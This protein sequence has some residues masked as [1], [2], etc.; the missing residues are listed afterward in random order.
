MR[1]GSSRTNEVIPDDFQT[2]LASL[3]DRCGNVEAIL[4]QGRTPLC[5]AHLYGC[6]AEIRAQLNRIGIGRGDRVAAA[7]PRGP[8]TAV[9]FFGVA[10]CATY[11]PLNPDYSEDEFGRYLARLQPKAV[12]VRNGDGAAIRNA[13]TQ[14]GIRIV[15]LVAVETGPAGKFELRCDDSGT[16]AEPEWATGEDIALI[17]L[18]SGSTACPKLVPLKQRHLLAYARVAKAHFALDHRDRNLHTMPMFHGQGLKSALTVPIL[19]GCGVICPSDFDVPSFFANMAEL[20][21]TWYSASYTIQQAILNRI[22]DYHR[23]ASEAKLRFIVSGAGRIDAK[24]VRGLEVAFGAPVIERY[25]M[26][27]TG[28]LACGALP[29][30]IRKAGAIGKPVLN[31]I[32]I[33]GEDGAFLPSDK[34]GE[35][36]TRGPGVFEGYLDEPEINAAT[37]IAGWFR[38]GDLGRV[39]ED[40]YLTITGRIKE[41]INRGGEK[42][43]PAE[44]ERTIAEHPAVAAVCV[45]GIP[46]PTLGEE[47]VAAV[48]PV[49]G[50]PANDRSIIEFANTRLASF[51]V[52]RGIAFIADFPQLATGKIDRKAL[53]QR[54][55]SSA[56]P[57]IREISNPESGRSSLE[58]AVASLW[59]RL[60]E[61]EQA[62]PDLDFFL[63]GGDSLKL[64][65]L[66]VAIRQQFGVH[67]SMRDILDEGATV[68]GLAGLI[69]RAQHDE[70]RFGSLPEGLLPIKAGG[71]RPTLFAIPGTDG[72]P[73]SFVH[74]GRWLDVRQPLYGLE[75]RGLDGIS[76]P[77]DRI[78]DIAADHLSAIR[79]FQPE[80]PYYLIGACFGGR[81]AYEMARQLLAAGERVALLIMLDPPP[82]FTNS[83]GLRRGRAPAHEVLRKWSRLPRFVL[84]RLRLYAIEVGRLDGARRTAYFRAKLNLVREIVLRRDPFRGDRSEIQSIAVDEA[85]RA[86]GRRYIP[87]PYAGPAIIALTDGR[88][89][90]GPRNFRFDWIDLV[91]QCG[92]P[93]YVPGRDTG[94]MLIPPNVHALATRLNDWLAVAQARAGAPSPVEPSLAVTGR[95]GQPA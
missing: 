17:L 10:A 69:E 29:P 4:A 73:G 50:A 74:L 18:T 47:V 34:E 49:T 78:E 13:A 51:K 82:P 14:L 3:A 61:I 60:L 46:H 27:E 9:C 21:P 41:L 84:H 2:A 94:D 8:E 87:G 5:F 36:V 16:C 70:R 71:D 33:M 53:A 86:A 39:D 89:I 72:N 65:E 92:S 77:L 28:L 42:I 85:N 44:V 54:Y 26:S 81:V 76:A 40:G 11:A 88:G 43:A 58:T 68:I 37:F 62:R 75:S 80:G 1:Q 31:E 79:Q 67:V 63:S 24:V 7:L 30:G 57:A 66:L 19:A 55:I 95:A 56:P 52:P 15:E 35:V 22:H 83:H 20:R 48:I 6:V 91:P 25:S 64:A 45:F 32:R 90:P 93:V 12:V 23:V 38:T 59:S